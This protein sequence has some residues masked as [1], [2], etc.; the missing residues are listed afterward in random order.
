MQFDET[1][2]V[3]GFIKKHRG[4]RTAPGD[5]ISRYAI[6]LPAADAE[7]SARVRAV[8]TDW[9]TAS[10]GNSMAAQIARMCRAEDRRL[11]DE[12]GAAMET[13][14]WWRQRQSARQSAATAS[15]ERA[16]ASLREYYGP[17][18]V[19]TRGAL[20]KSAAILKITSRQAAQAA[21]LAELRVLD[22]VSAPDAEPIGD[23]SALLKYMAECGADSVPDLVHPDAG[24]FSIIKGYAS[25]D[26]LGKRLDEAAVAAQID[27]AEESG[28][29]AA[30]NARLAALKILR[31]ALRARVDLRDVALYH[32][33]TIA[34][35]S[36]S[37]DTAEEKLRGTGLEIADAERIAVLPAEE[38]AV[39]SL[40]KIYQVETP[41]APSRQGT[42][43]VELS[44]VS[45]QISVASG[46]DAQP[47]QDPPAP[48]VIGPVRQ[49]TVTPF[50]T[51]ATV[52]WEWPSGAQFADLSWELDGRADGVRIDL[53][54]YT[55]EGGVKVPLG[56]GPC[57]IEVRAVFMDGGGSFT[58]SPVHDV[59][60][61]TV[62]V[63][64]QARLADPPASRVEET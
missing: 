1:Q 52:S 3:E 27:R 60:D 32:L 43:G 24:Q 31:T 2:Y 44:A 11:S 13:S 45:R 10:K 16:A 40:L 21:K 19:V 25:R 23:F 20:D 55:S 64:G 62:V 4:A 61:A 63:Q 22:N 29:S 35:D 59:I 54:Q 47:T 53:E 17:L 34:R 36:P 26:D 51:Y 57:A 39:D 7:I 15:I 48:T 49:L 8:R 41:N 46:T 5:L 12:H 38:H 18:G 58:S 30:D 33:I 6:A 50:A 14:A 9:D 56:H 28:I 42:D 37:K